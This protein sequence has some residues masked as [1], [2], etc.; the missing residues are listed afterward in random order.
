MQYRTF[1]LFNFQ[2][3]YPFPHRLG[4]LTLHQYLQP[5]K[6]H[7][8]QPGEVLAAAEGL[9]ARFGDLWIRLLGR[10]AWLA[11]EAE[12]AHGLAPSPAPPADRT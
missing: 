9:V 3:P 8:D 6:H 1:F 7:P 11:E 4:N 10:L 2:Q 5:E 12:K